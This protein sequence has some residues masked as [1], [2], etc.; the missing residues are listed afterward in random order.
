MLDQFSHP[1]LRVARRHPYREASPRSASD[2]GAW[3]DSN[4]ENALIVA[5]GALLL[6]A[7]VRVIVDVS[8]ARVDGEGVLALILCGVLAPKLMRRLKG[9]VFATND[10]RNGDS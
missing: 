6:W 1:K 2:E 7:F 3:N 10:A 5:Q 8:C 9:R 4:L